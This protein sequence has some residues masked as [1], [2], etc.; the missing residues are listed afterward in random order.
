M[1]RSLFRASQSGMSLLSLMAVLAILAMVFTFA[2]RLVPVYLQH[3]NVVASLKNVAAE[4]RNGG[5]TA[6][7]D[8]RNAMLRQFSVNDIDL[9]RDVITVNTTKDKRTEIVVD[10]EI[11]KPLLANIDLVIHFHNSVAF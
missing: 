2:I 10:Y 6:K 1:P 3:F 4:A 5:P 7:A 9:G 11:R 8:I